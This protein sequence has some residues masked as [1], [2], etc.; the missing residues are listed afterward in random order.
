MGDGASESL[1]PLCSA[2]SPGLTAAVAL[3]FSAS[4]CSGLALLALNGD[5]DRHRVNG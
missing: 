3:L 5:V 1:P 2:C 4:L